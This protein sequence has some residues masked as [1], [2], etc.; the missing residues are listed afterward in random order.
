MLWSCTTRSVYYNTVIFTCTNRHY[1]RHVEIQFDLVA[2]C[3]FVFL[4]F[5]HYVQNNTYKMQL[6][7]ICLHFYFHFCV[8]FILICFTDI[9][10]TTTIRSSICQCGH[11]IANYYICLYDFSL[12]SKK[13]LINW[14]KKNLKSHSLSDW[15]YLSVFVCFRFDSSRVKEMMLMKKKNNWNKNKSCQ[16]SVLCVMAKRKVV[17]LVDHCKL[18]QF[19]IIIFTLAL[20]FIQ[21]YS[22]T[23]EW[24][25]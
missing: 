20:F 2:V 23:I 6:T 9:K 10:L 24:E 13:W 5:L 21:N 19:L 1:N 7:T 11:C 12:K 15:A 3:V 8:I 17:L 14:S 16:S 18:Y 25:W 22:L 4:F